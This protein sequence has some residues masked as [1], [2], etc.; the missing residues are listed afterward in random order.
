MEHMSTGS[1]QTQ[2]R[3]LD[4]PPEGVGVQPI[5]T[6]HPLALVGKMG[7]HPGDKLQIIH[8]LRPMPRAATSPAIT[9]LAL[10]HQK[11]EVHVKI[12]PV[13]KGLDGGDDQNGPR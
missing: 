5:V 12:D 13:P 8:H 2:A 6:D 4:L 3:F 9:D 11:M 7:G 1:R 10:G